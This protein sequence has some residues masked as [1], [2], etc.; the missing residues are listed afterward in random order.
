MFHPTRF[1]RLEL[2]DPQQG[3]IVRS[4]REGWLQG[5]IMVTT[6]STRHRR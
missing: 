6:F 1:R 5:F 4:E 2:D 3:Y